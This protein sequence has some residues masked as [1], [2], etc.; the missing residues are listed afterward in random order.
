MS[1]ARTTLTA[2]N[3][4]VRADFDTKLAG[5]DSRV[6]R[7]VIDVAAGAHAGVA[8]TLYGEIESNSH[9]LPGDRKM[10]TARLELWVSAFMSAGRKSAEA[11]TGVVTLIGTDT[12]VAPAGTILTRAD[13]ARYVITADATIVAETAAAAVTALDAGVDGGMATGQVLTFASPIAGI[14]ATAA[15]AAPGIIGG[16]DEESDDALHDRLLER[17]R[18]PVRGGS[19]TD[20]VIWAKEVPEVTR[21]WVYAN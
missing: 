10:S 14:Q 17:L 1:F 7:N 16:V 19:A 15:V 18:N 6:R 2:L 13:G 20:Y 3:A 12:R 8:N 21:A 5:A 9:F 4:R 11:A